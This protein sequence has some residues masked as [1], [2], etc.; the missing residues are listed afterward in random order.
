MDDK[1]GKP[2]TIEVQPAVLT[3][4]IEYG[5]E[6]DDDEEDDAEK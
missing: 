6:D 5:K 2:L 4:K 3:A 1:E